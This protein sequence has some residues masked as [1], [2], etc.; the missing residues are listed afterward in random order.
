MWK[1]HSDS[2]EWWL[3]FEAFHGIYVSTRVAG[4]SRR[5]HMTH[6]RM[7]CPTAHD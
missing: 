7:E 1:E 2:S 3:K 5:S 6:G 4:S